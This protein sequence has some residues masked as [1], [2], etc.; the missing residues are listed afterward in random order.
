[1]T[2]HVVSMPHT[3]TT[4]AFDWCPF[5]SGARKFATMM[6][7]LGYDVRLYG[8]ESNEAACAEHIQVVSR[9]EQKEWFGQYDWSRDVFN[10]N[11]STK[12]WWRTMNARA[13]DE[14]RKRSKP[15]D[16]LGLVMGLVQHPIQEQ[17][18]AA[19]LYEV[20]LGIGYTLPSSPFRIFVSHALR[21][22][23]A[24]RVPNDDL[25]PF[26]TVIPN[27][28]EVN[29]FPEGSGTGDYYLFVGRATRRKG[30][31]IAAEVCKKLGAKLLVAGQGIASGSPVTTTEGIVLEGDVE[32]VGLV[33]PVRRAEL[34]GNAKALFVPTIYL[35]PFG[36][37]A[38]EAMMCGTPV[39]TSDWGGFTETVVD[40]VTGFRCNTIPE[41]LDA[42]KRV[43]D[44]DR[45]AIRAYAIEKYSTE[46]V[47]HQY[48]RYFQ[49][50]ARDYPMYAERQKSSEQRRLEEEERSVRQNPTP[51]KYLNLSLLYGKQLR[52][53]DCIAAAKEALLLRPEYAEAY[54]NI[55]AS[56]Q[57]LEQWDL[58][59]EAAKRAVRIN[60][61][62]K[63]AQG[64]LM[65]SITQRERVRS[66]PGHDADRLPVVALARPGGIGDILA[67]LNLIPTIKMANPG[68]EIWY[69]CHEWY[70]RPENL[71]STIL[72]AGC[73]KVLDEL[74]FAYWSTRTETPVAFGWPEDY[75][76]FPGK[77]AAAQMKHLLHYFAA[78]A[79]VAFEESNFPSLRIRKPAR[80]NVPAGDYATLQWKAQWSVYKEWP[81]DRWQAVIAQLDFPVIVLDPKTTPHLED[82]IALIANA[83][84]HIGIDSFAQHVT[85]FTWVDA[86]GNGRKI[87]SVI[88]WGSTQPRTMSYPHNTG[89]YLDLP[90]QPCYRCGPDRPQ[91]VVSKL[92]DNPPGQTYQD[93]RHACM[94][95]ISVE[96]VVETIRAKWREAR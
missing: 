52:H 15:G 74:E 9:A 87:P 88:L 8:G 78:E 39:I 23:L 92:C 82:A 49:R 54:N 22:F 45:K 79:G 89:I 76:D 53:G 5:T 20:E 11:D 62:L 80:P 27:S 34:M 7:S 96:R 86:V 56:Y 10:P 31:A 40:G 70:A 93:P 95:G 44:L 66:A 13:A 57:A 1:M 69:F 14:I 42:A 16:V 61:N 68:K 94:S 38:V 33:D 12:P 59:V 58:A 64:N 3:E 50:L 77:P 24:D 55:S 32:Y 83:R 43:D 26:D 60:K 17:L 72:A 90:C 73:D 35:E 29:D 51:E 75:D 25:R 65:H 81:F 47:R 36:N 18:T 2:L 21:H 71:G 84:M 67:S 63:L 19:G 6:T 48:D 28:F 46:V 37:V 4:R 85:N 91:R 41:Y 30:P